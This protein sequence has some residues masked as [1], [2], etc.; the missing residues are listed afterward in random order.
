M[1]ERNST[2]SRR[3][4]IGVVLSV[5]LT[6]GISHLVS[7]RPGSAPHTVL[8][9]V[10]QLRADHLG[11]YGYQRPT[12]PHLDQLAEDAVVFEN[13]I[14]AS[15]FTKTSIASLFTGLHPYHHGVYRGIKRDAEGEIISDVLDPELDTLAAG[16]SR[17]G[18]ETAAWVQN[19]HLRRIYGFDRGFSRYRDRAGSLSKINEGYLRWLRR[20]SRRSAS[21]AYLHYL[22]LHGPNRPKPDFDGRFG[23]FNPAFDRTVFDD[24]GQFLSDVKHGKVRLAE[25]DIQQLRADYDAV[26]AWVDE[27][28]GRVFAELKRRGVYH[29]ALIVVTSDHGEGFMEHGFLGHARAPYDVLVRVPLLVKLPK[30]RWG[31]RTVRE[32]VQLVDVAPTILD[33]AA[34]ASWL[35]DGRSLRPFLDAARRPQSR[36]NYAISEYRD[37]VAVRT[38]ERKLIRRPNGSYEWYD[39]ASD[40]AER[41]NRSHLAADDPVFRDMRAQAERIANERRRTQTSTVDTATAEELRAL[42]YLD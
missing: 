12:T 13:A 1:R 41:F 33:L 27:G 39:L 40:P 20:R 25:A 3:L 36:P 21:F 10:D 29:D 11:C 19:G 5:T 8:I 7:R 26:L 18:F 23:V 38:K 2:L 17:A 6:F 16:L 31:G 34:S 15:T 30:N 42:A 22:D 14:A 32:Q 4:A 9:V 28:L 37:T 35:G 24:Y